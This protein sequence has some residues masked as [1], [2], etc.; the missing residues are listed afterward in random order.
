MKIP[1]TRTELYGTPDFAWNNFCRVIKDRNDEYSPV[2]ETASLCY[3]YYTEIY[4]YRDWG[5]TDLLEEKGIEAIEE[6]EWYHGHLDFFDYCEANGIDTNELMQALETIGAPEFSKNLLNA[7]ES[8]RE[9][10]NLDASLDARADVCP[11]A[12]LDA[13]ADVCP[14]AC[15]DADVW[16]VEHEEALLDA[17]R[18]YWRSN[19]E[20][21]YE[22]IDEDYTMRPPKD[23]FWV[24]VFIAGFVCIM[25]IIASLTNP[26]PGDRQMFLVISICSLIST[27]L[28]LFLYAKRW[29]MTIKKD[30]M[31]IRF[32]FLIKKRISFD[33]ISDMRWSKRGVI[34]H[35]HGKRLLFIRNDVKGYETFCT[36]LSLDRKQVNE[37]AKFTIKR[38][39]PKKIEGVMW[40]LACITFLAW[41]LSRQ[42]NP[43]GIIEIGI[44]SAPIPVALFYMI[45]I[46]RWRITVFE[47]RIRIRAALSAEKEYHIADIT[48]VELKKKRAHFFTADGKSFSMEYSEGYS[49]LTQ[50]LQNEGIPFY[51][52]GE[53]I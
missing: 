11:D 50:K 48:K 49:E 23:G 10:N 46:M 12:C 1:I 47:S 34:I 39:I 38:S 28:V 19:L 40:P 36:Q 37:P 43:A 41:S 25:M 24:A 7:V 31:T 8:Q 17:I 35:A 27:G 52:D 30:E 3:T 15:L 14:D 4:D 6:R 53:L 32:L 9:G 44:L 20:E 2:Q 26:D 13:R 21:F 42:V 16:F 5:G 29:K 45:H 22:I 51:K 33:E 18:D